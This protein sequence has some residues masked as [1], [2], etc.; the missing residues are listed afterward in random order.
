MPVG[1]PI[2]AAAAWNSDSIMFAS[3]ASASVGSMA[4]GRP[5]AHKEVL[6]WSM[7]GRRQFLDRFFQSSFFE[8]FCETPVKN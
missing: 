1:M 5:Q 7:S 2:D 3:I 4:L 8:H 6:V